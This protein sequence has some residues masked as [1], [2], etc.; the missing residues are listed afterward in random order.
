MTNY[1]PLDIHTRNDSNPRTFYRSCETL[2]TDVAH[3]ISHTIYKPAYWCTH[4]FVARL[5]WRACCLFVTTTFLPRLHCMNWKGL[6]LRYPI[7]SICCLLI[8]AARQIVNALFNVIYAS[9]SSLSLM[10]SSRTPNTTLSRIMSLS[11]VPNS[12]FAALERRSVTH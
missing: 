7:A 2:N 11:N 5:R 4:V 12:H 1:A 6:C 9:R 3:A 8:S 10:R